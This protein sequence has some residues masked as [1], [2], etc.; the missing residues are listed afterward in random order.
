MAPKDFQYSAVIGGIGDILIHD[1]VY[2]DAKTEK[3]YNFKPMF[4]PVKS[5]LQKP[6]FL[7]ANQESIPGG[8]TLVLSTY[9]SFKIADAIIDAG[10]DF[11]STANN[12]A[13]DKGEAGIKNS[14][15]YYDKKNLPYVGTFKNEQDQNTLRIQNVNGIK[16]AILAYT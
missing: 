4:Q 1:W 14:I 10:V 12:H 15:S 6:D 9:P 3:G 2:K 7:I 5:I 16:I 11:V 8:E 13:L